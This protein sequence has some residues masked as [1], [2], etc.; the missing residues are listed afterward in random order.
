MLAE[1][2][3][4]QSLRRHIHKV[5]CSCCPV[6]AFYIIVPV[7]GALD[8]DDCCE[9]SEGC[10]HC[11]Q[12]EHTYLTSAS[13][14]SDHHCAVQTLQIRSLHCAYH[15]ER[16]VNSVFLKF[17]QLFILTS[18]LLLS[19]T[20]IGCEIGHF[21]ASHL[22]QF[23]LFIIIIRLW[24]MFCFKVSLKLYWLKFSFSFH[25]LNTLT[26]KTCLEYYSPHHNSVSVAEAAGYSLS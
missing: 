19:S 9:Y 11:P 23:D 22:V 24:P 10:W 17:S 20:Q 4:V 15:Q 1:L 16:Q 2:L 21:E 12:I 13:C 26:L 8:I 25:P 14:S 7:E 3:L 18:N 6:M 5:L